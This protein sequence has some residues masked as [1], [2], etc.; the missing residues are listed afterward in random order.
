MII[1]DGGI[2]FDVPMTCKKMY[3]DIIDELKQLIVSGD[4]EKFSKVYKWDDDNVRH[5]ISGFILDTK[6]FE[7]YRSL[8]TQNIIRNDFYDFSDAVDAMTN[9]EEFEKLLMQ[10]DNWGLRLMWGR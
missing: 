6:G 2:F 5:I 7:F 3:E 4:I 10:N 8:V 1:E 9:C